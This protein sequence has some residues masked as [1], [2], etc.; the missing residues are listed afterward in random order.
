MAQTLRSRGSAGHGGLIRSLL[1]LV[2][3]LAALAE[4]RFALFIKE[5]KTTLV[6]V[7][8]LVACLLVALLFF[9]LG[10]IFLIASIIVAVARAAQVSWI[11]IALI[12]AGCHF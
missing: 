10:Y 5:S 7:I 6:Q 1:T 2:A 12:A 4:S 11:W 3:D 9:M 8:V